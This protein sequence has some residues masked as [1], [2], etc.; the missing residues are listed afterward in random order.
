[1]T[2][3]DI[4]ELISVNK[5]RLTTKRCKHDSLLAAGEPF[6]LTGL[7]GSIR[8]KQ[9]LKSCSEACCKFW[10]WARSAADA[11]KVVGMDVESNH[12]GKAHLCWI[13][14]PLQCLSSWSDQA[15]RENS[16]CFFVICEGGVYYYH[17]FELTKCFTHC[18]NPAKVSCRGG[19]CGRQKSA[20]LLCTS[21]LSTWMVFVCT[22]YLKSSLRLSTC[23]VFGSSLQLE[24]GNVLKVCYRFL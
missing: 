16:A 21:M 10:L 6:D 2:A 20:H 12:G 23:L 22:C 5:H 13:R 19:R 8:R 14:W 1:M 3:S 9:T 4:E 17:D 24:N 15:M 7:L 11:C 18:A